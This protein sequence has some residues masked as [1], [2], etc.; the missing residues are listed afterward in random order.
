MN[1]IMNDGR[2]IDPSW[3]L[4]RCATYDVHNLWKLEYAGGKNPEFKPCNLA[5]LNS[6]VQEFHSHWTVQ[7]S[8]KR[9]RPSSSGD[10]MIESGERKVV[11]SNAYQHLMRCLGADEVCMLTLINFHN[12][13]QRH[14]NIC[15]TLHAFSIYGRCLEESA[16]NIAEKLAD[17]MKVMGAARECFAALTRFSFFVGA[18]QHQNSCDLLALTEPKTE[19][20]TTF[21]AEVDWQKP[22]KERHDMEMEAIASASFYLLEDPYSS[23]KLN[24]FQSCFLYLRR[25]LDT[26]G[27]RKVDGK[28]FGR[29]DIPP[30]GY[31]A[32]AFEERETVD[33]FVSEYLSHSASF[34]MWSKATSKNSPVHKSLVD[35][36]TER[37]LQETPPL[38]ESHRIRSYAGDKFGRGAVVYC[39]HSDFAFDYWDRDMWHE[40]ARD[41]LVK[42]RGLHGGEV[43]DKSIDCQA[44]SED[45]VCM[46]H[47]DCVFPYDTVHEL[48]ELHSALG[49]GTYYFREA[50][51]F[52]CERLVP[53]LEEISDVLHS[54]VAPLRIPLNGETV[55]RRWRA[56]SLLESH[57]M[58]HG[59]P[60]LKKTFGGS[61]FEGEEHLSL[62]EK[63][64][65]RRKDLGLPRHL[66][67]VQG[68]RAPDM[69]TSTVCRLSLAS[70]P[71]RTIPASLCYYDCDSRRVYVP[72]IDLRMQP[73]AAVTR[74]GQLWTAVANLDME[75]EYV[76]QDD[77]RVLDL[78]MQAAGSSVL[79]DGQVVCVSND[80]RPTWHVDPDLAVPT[81][82]GIYIV[83][84]GILPVD[85]ILNEDTLVTHA[86]SG[87]HFRLDTGRTWL[88]CETR[89]I[90]HIW[91]C[92]RFDDHDK[93]HLYASIGRLFFH[94]GEKDPHQHT[95]FLEG[96]GGCGKSTMVNTQMMFWPPHKRGILSSNIEP[97]FGMS[98]VMMEGEAE[99][100]FC[101][102]VAT[103]LKVSQEEWQNSSSGE[104][105]SYAVK[106]QKPLRI[107]CKAP[108]FWVGNSKPG[109]RNESNQMGRRL[110]AVLMPYP[111]RPRDGKI[112]EVIQ[113]KLGPLQRREILAYREY[114]KIHGQTDPMSMPEKLPPAF[115]EY[116]MRLRRQTDPIQDFLSEGS[117]VVYDEHSV[118]LMERFRALYDQYRSQYD[119]PKPKRWGDELYRMAFSERCV[120][121]RKGT[122]NVDGADRHNVEYISGLR[123]VSL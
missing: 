85:S 27:Y 5:T 47:L 80:D 89:E 73:R 22:S 39:S 48:D 16:F 71:V 88:D 52:E 86:A 15:T 59:K 96:T 44:P 101:N 26:L 58:V 29:I 103:N 76:I 37:E 18:T 25:H 68:R 32:M 111:V 53:S 74:V 105:A 65:I 36:L 116:H 69:G 30:M 83:Q 99:V 23:K 110:N 66:D 2:G 100:I 112:A 43:S 118:M 1:D 41:V 122:V 123:D 95:T 12:L 114:C 19:N 109:F 90:D 31:A 50:L 9:A 61:V 4:D 72:Y 102:E 106:N 35:Y 117:Y 77:G 46:V 62:D 55:G 84:S 93:F 78:V 42:R 8:K 56:L 51:P 38:V 45:K 67:E 82:Y 98:Q 11:P 119:V 21:M 24:A 107:K 10:V 28:Y 57:D 49:N 92:Q 70:D 60:S 81:G 75:R 115:R 113:R 40:R 33:K 3:S 97:L 6:L 94:V 20:G 104:V 7:V 87:R 64:E 91:D 120:E 121:V 54:S 14:L 13:L 17:V 63:D 79:T 108:H 34:T